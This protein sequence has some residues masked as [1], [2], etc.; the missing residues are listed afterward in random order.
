MFRLAI[1]NLATNKIRLG[2]T[3]LAIVLGVGFVVSSFILRDGLKD[4][5]GSLSDAVVEGID[6]AVE[7][8]PDIPGTTRLTSADIE[9]VQNIPGVRVAEGDLEA[10]ENLI[11]PILDDGT[12]ITLNGPPQLMLNWTVDEGL[13]PSE[14]LSGR[15]PTGPDEWVVD[16]DSAAEH[17]FVLDTTYDMITPSGRKTASLVGIFAFEGSDV[18]PTFMAM[19]TS[20]LRDYRAPRRYVGSNSDCRRRIC[21]AARRPSGDRHCTEQQLPTG[22]GPRSGQ[23]RR[24]ISKPS[25]TRRSTSSVESCSDS[26]WWRC[27]FRSS[28]SPTRSRSRQASGPASWVCSERSERHQARYS[29]RS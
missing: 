10:V 24:T 1:K 5:F 23:P 16:V 17:N 19:E 15:A 26:P 28:S 29:G 7:L 18:G 8:D 20:A 27:S 13:S 11:Q 4:T 14:L 6:L 22:R 25:S 21:A 3:A 2:L 12:T 9:T